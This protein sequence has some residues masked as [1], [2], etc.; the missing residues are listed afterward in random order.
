MQKKSFAPH[1]GK[2][3]TD[4]HNLVVQS[5]NLLINQTYPTKEST[6]EKFKQLT[7]NW[8]ELS[9][10]QQEGIT[11]ELNTIGWLRRGVCWVHKDDI[12]NISVII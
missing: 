3:L 4:T 8:N 12:E 2:L 6:L 7:A 5:Y 1:T 10:Q 9:I 11:K